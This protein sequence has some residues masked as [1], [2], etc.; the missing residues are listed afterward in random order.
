MKCN[1]LES[2]RQ[3]H[4]TENKKLLENLAAEKREKIGLLNDV[5]EAKNLIT[6][7]DAEMA[8]MKSSN[9]NLVIENERLTKQI[10]TMNLQQINVLKEKQAATNSV[11][12]L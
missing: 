5:T 11:K 6:R 2:E 12:I 9:S 7:K 3:R 8:T 10:E 4:L 1:A